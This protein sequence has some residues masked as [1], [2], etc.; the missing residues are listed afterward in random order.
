[1]TAA[2]VCCVCV[3]VLSVCVC[4]NVCDCGYMCLCPS[5][6][7]LVSGFYAMFIVEFDHKRMDICV[8]L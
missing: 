6:D 2:S 8:Q 1:M 7:L 3:N 5:C 4:M